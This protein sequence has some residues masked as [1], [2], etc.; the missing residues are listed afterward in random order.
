[1][2][3]KIPG[4]PPG[5]SLN[6]TKGPGCSP[7]GELLWRAG[8]AAAPLLGEEK[9]LRRAPAKQLPPRQGRIPFPDLVF[10][11]SWEPG[12]GALHSANEFSPCLHPAWRPGGTVACCDTV[13]TQRARPQTPALG[14][15]LE[16]CRRSPSLHPSHQGQGRARRR[17][18]VFT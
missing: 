3:K 10:P 6:I 15:S 16:S 8:G 1:L 4:I 18:R 5:P 2:L 9:T 11:W 13:K 14:L 7:W 12:A 17:V